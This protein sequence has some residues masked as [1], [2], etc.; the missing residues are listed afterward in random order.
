MGTQSNLGFVVSQLAHIETEVFERKYPDIQYPDL[1]D[2]DTSAH[3]WAKTVTYY[4]MDG[5]GKAQF[6]NGKAGD[7]PLVSTQMADSE[8]KVDMAAIGYDYS[9]EEINQAMALGMSLDTMKAHYARRAYEDMVDGVALTGDT[10]R[11]WT[12]LFN[13]P[14]VTV[15]AAPNGASA[16][17]L[18]SNKTPLEII[19]DINDVITG[20]HVATKTT[21]MAD[22]VLLPYERLSPLTSIV[23]PN[24]SMTVL[25]FIKE[26]NLY[27]MTTGQPL[28][29]RGVRG[30]VQAGGGSSARMIAYRKSPEVA[31]LHIPLPLEFLQPEV[32]GLSVIVPGIFRLGGLDIRLPGEVRYLDGI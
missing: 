28:K 24:T 21:G 14:A 25:Q 9:I 19:K 26:N 5:V 32:R 16:S 23:L 8:T 10:G 31:K 30:L 29:L 17:P 13:S 6:M 11:G 2:V 4:S 27:T 7:V 3:P 15:V 12:G 22:T 18:W 1:I 20:V